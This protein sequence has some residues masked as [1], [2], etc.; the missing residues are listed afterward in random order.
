MKGPSLPSGLRLGL[1]LALTIALARQEALA[2]TCGSDVFVSA[3]SYPVGAFP[4][5]L[6]VAD[7]NGDGIPDLATLSNYYYGYSISVLLGNPDGTFLPAI[8]TALANPP[9]AFTAGNFDGDGKADIVV[10]FSDYYD[11]Y[12]E[13]LLGNGDG[14]FQS[15]IVSPVEPPFALYGIKAAQFSSGGELGLAGVGGAASIVLFAGNGDGTFGAPAS[16]PTSIFVDRLVLGDVDGDGNLDAVALHTS[17]NTLAVLLGAGNG[18][19]GTPHLVIGGSGLGEATLADFNGDGKTDIAVLAG[20][21]VAVLL[22]NGDATF[23]APRDYPVGLSALHL[24]VGDVDGDGHPDLAVGNSSGQ[25]NET[26]GVQL[27]RG[28]GDGSFLNGPSYSTGPSMAGLAVADLGADG[29]FDVATTEGSPGTVSVLLGNGDG[30]LRAVRTD[31]FGVHPASLAAGD[32][33]GD[34][35]T[36]LAAGVAQSATLKI[37]LQDPLTGFHTGQ[38]FSL[39]DTITNVGAGD[40]NEDGNADVVALTFYND[41]L[42]LLLGNGDGTFQTPAPLPLPGYQPTT[43]TVADFNSD[44]HLDLGITGGGGDLFGKYTVLLGNG[45]GTFQSPVTSPVF[46]T[47]NSAGYGDLDGDGIADLAL[48]NGDYYGADVVSVLLGRGDGTFGTPQDYATG[49]DPSFVAIGDFNDD[50]VP[51][52][53]VANSGESTVSVLFGVGNGTFQDGTFLGQGWRPTAVV[54]TDFDNDG[55]ADIVTAS[56]EGANATLLRGLGDGAFD[57]PV[58]YTVGTVP[59]PMLVTDVAGN[60]TPDVVIGNS[61]GLGGVSLLLNSRLS[62]GALPPFGACIGSAALL[63]AHAG[64]LGPLTYQW[65][66]DGANLV[67]GGSISGATT[68]TLTINPAASSDDGNYDV[69]V[70]N[71]CTAVT[72]NTTTLTVTDPPPTPVIAIGA[73]PAPSVAGTASVFA[74]VGHTYVW[75]VTGA[76]I[77]S[78]QGTSDI[79]FLTPLPGTVTLQVVDYAVPGCGTSS[80]AIDV[81]VDFFDVPPSS[82][83][84]ADIVA[85]AQLGIT[86]GCGA[87]NY[88]PALPVTR[89]QM[90]VFLLKAL[91]GA[92]HVPPSFGQIF[93]DVPPGSFAYDWINELWS[94]GVTTGCGGGN[95]CPDNSVTR[96]QMAVF[97][98]KTHLGAGY[99]PPPAAGIFGDVPVGSFAADWIEDLYNRGIT[100]GCSANPL[101]YCPANA[102]NRGQMATFLVRT[103]LTP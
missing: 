54:A 91:F 97:L 71:S 83:F 61:G 31:A 18:T 53:V 85:I 90:A 21:Y 94:L 41:Q 49:L 4:N 26:A 2:A 11:N 6:L 50:G 17:G 29:L 39:Q 13:T 80:A 72:S 24:A 44:G 5:D 38:T 30:T 20:S 96:A 33:D 47:A 93:Q 36:D 81:P 28:L 10:S 70:A 62:V 46:H 7:F 75:T 74:T 92:N 14:T 52:L 86:A 95:Y 68:A 84:H 77:V 40:F 65:R 1:C 16:F 82:L 102:V 22:G 101:L 48:T 87:G 63:R 58:V 64:G 66:K 12:I 56:R 42:W 35:L 15:P 78:G 69:V 32:F 73:L 100:G 88:C 34:G 19:L 8:S 76:A 3:S 89:A 59:S 25:G 103:F 67:D 98:L 27:L 99:A 79:Q 57:S 55:H 60:G 51:D 45:D 23:Q 43:L 37:L 9:L